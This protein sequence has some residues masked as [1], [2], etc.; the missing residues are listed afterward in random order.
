MVQ[1]FSFP[2]RMMMI[3][4]WFCVESWTQGLTHAKQVLFWAMTI[5]GLLI[6]ILN[7]L[8]IT[9]GLTA[10]GVTDLQTF[11]DLQSEESLALENP[12]TLR[13]W[14]TFY[15]SCLSGWTSE[16]SI[17]ENGSKNKT[18]RF[19]GVQVYEAQRIFSKPTACPFGVLHSIGTQ[20]KSK[21]EKQRKQ[22]SRG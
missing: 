3:W 8:K 21:S 1:C 18:D 6:N 22:D 19:G 16:H 15:S 7:L 12:I 14:W 2:G 10:F 9:A 11:T 17:D 13:G 4:W 20:G 5:P